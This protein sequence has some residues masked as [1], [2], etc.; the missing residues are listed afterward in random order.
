M[1]EILAQSGSPMSKPF[2]RQSKLLHASLKP[3]L[4]LSSGRGRVFLCER[5]RYQG[6]EGGM[7]CINKECV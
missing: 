2:F 7:V 1:R 5:F 3:L 6:I 4:M